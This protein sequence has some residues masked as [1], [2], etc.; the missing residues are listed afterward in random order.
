[1]ASCSVCGAEA[2]LPYTCSYCGASHCGAHRLPENHDC[3]HRETARTLGPEL[4]DV[5]STSEEPQ[6]LYL[7]GRPSG[8]VG[9]LRWLAAGT[10]SLLRRHARTI[11]IGTL[12][13]LAA[14]GAAFVLSL[15]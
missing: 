15:V 3:P 6:T 9:T 14:V 10:G 8:P 5:A 12:L 2:S 13:V 1:M 11:A 4:R 7:G